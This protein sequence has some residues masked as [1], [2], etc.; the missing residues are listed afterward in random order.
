MTPTQRTCL[1][2]LFNWLLQLP[3][4]DGRVVHAEACIQKA[5]LAGQHGF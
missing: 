2:D 4:D 1:Q 3:L 5:G